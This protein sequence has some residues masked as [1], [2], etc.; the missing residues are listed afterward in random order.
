MQNEHNNKGMGAPAQK[1]PAT[2]T[3]EFFYPGEMVYEPMTIKARDK[4]EADA[5]YEKERIEVK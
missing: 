4:A 1:A 5:L 2:K 3:E